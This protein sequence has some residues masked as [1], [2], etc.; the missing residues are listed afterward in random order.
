MISG[1][2]LAL[3]KAVNNPNDDVSAVGGAMSSTELLGATGE[4]IPTYTYLSEGDSPITWYYKVFFKN[5]HAS[6]TLSSPRYWVSNLLGSSS[7]AANISVV[8]SSA[9]DNYHK[10]RCYFTDAYGVNTYEDIVMNGISP[11]LGN[12]YVEAGSLYKVEYQTMA[13]NL[14]SAN[15]DISITQGT[16]LGCIPAGCDFATAEALFALETDDGGTPVVAVDQAGTADNR[17]TAPTQ[18]TA[19]SSA[20]TVGASLLGAD[21]PAGSGQGIWIKIS[22][23]VGTLPTLQ[24][25]LRFNISGISPA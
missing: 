10:C 11:V 20:R 25:R 9:A 3:F 19:W 4:V 2:D 17:T 8:S 14:V 6:S 21:L 16:L 1:T 13:G 15:G 23:A 22:G 24:N 12:A 5:K 7:V 18:I